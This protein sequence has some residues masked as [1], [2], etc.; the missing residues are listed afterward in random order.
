ML[1]TWI[2]IFSLAGTLGTAIAA[3]LFLFSSQRL[4]KVV[5]PGLLSFAVGA[6]LSVAFLRLLPLA[7]KNAEVELIMGTVLGGIILFFILEKTLIWRHCH[8]HE[9]E[10]H[11][12]GGPLILIGDAFHNFVDG[13][14]IAAAFLASIPLGVATA[15]AIVIHEV[16]QEVGDFSILLEQGYPVRRAFILNGISSLATC[17]GALVG[18]FILDLVEPAIPFILAISASSF[19]YIAT[20]DLIADMHRRPE[21]Q[22]AVSQTLLILAGIA[23]VALF[24]MGHSH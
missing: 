23:S 3:S 19:I 8:E 2:I 22:S 4:K 5:L 13:V 6:L 24:G 17:L 7:V 21:P 9:C 12:A 20:V 18:Y 11:T 16:P 15:L 10:V 1:L 14:I